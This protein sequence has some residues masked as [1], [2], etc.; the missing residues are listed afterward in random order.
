VVNRSLKGIDMLEESLGGG[1]GREVALDGVGSAARAA[2]A[3]RADSASRA[4]SAAQADV[5]GRADDADRFAGQ[6]LQGFLR[7]NATIPSGTT[8]TGVWGGRE[9]QAGDADGNA[10]TPYD[11]Y[12]FEQAVSLPLPAPVDLTDATVNYAANNPEAANLADDQDT[13][14]TGSPAAPSA[15]PGKVCIYLDSPLPAVGF[16]GDSASGLALAGSP[17]LGF[18]IR[19]PAG[20][21][22]DAVSS[23]ASGHQIRGSWA[24]TAP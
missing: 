10:S 18:Y 13:S 11:L 6:S 16:N 23:G 8:V 17:R 5:A 15:P 7:F 22:T 12:R 24:Y 19:G 9:Q 2:S 1:E 4:D 21:G 20:T 14:C 3:G